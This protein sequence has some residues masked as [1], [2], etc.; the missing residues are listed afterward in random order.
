MVEVEE[1]EEEEEEVFDFDAMEALLQLEAHAG[2]PLL[3]KQ[4]AKRIRRGARK[5]L[6]P[7]SSIVSGREEVSRWAYEADSMMMKITAPFL[8]S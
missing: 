4:R 8:P 2:R 3:G 7:T 1:D 5:C 6:P